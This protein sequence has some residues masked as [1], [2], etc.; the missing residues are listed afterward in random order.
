MIRHD[1]LDSLAR[2]LPKA[3][4][5]KGCQCRFSPR[6]GMPSKRLKPGLEDDLERGC[7]EGLPFPIGWYRVLGREGASSGKDAGHHRQLEQEDAPTAA[8]H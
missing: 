3:S 1:K 4:G 5:L 2:N 6:G 7:G 8:Q